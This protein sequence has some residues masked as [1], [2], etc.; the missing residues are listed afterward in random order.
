[1]SDLQQE[2]T[3]SADIDD[4]TL[5]TRAADG[6]VAAFEMLLRRYQDRVFG[7]ALRM[8]ADRAEAEDV[9]Q[10]VFVTAWRRLGELAEPAAVRTWLFRIAHRQCLVLLRK[11]KSRKTEPTDTVPE[12]AAVTRHDP[13]RAAQT[14]AGVEAL[15][16]ALAGLPAPQRAVWLLAEVDGLSYAEIAGVVG[17]SEQSVRG[18]LSRARAKLAEVMRA[19]R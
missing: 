3:S 12:T 19:W 15:R 17:A 9:T 8:L 14:G 5:A 11:R 7:L 16:K 13:E 6:D 2:E 10:E 18:R 4:A 1:M